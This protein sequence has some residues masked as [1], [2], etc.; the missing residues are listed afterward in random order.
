MYYVL[1]Y[2]TTLCAFMS[3][4]FYSALPNCKHIFFTIHHSFLSFLS[5]LNTQSP[6]LFLLFPFLSHHHGS[7]LHISHE[8]NIYEP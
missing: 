5:R 6:S 3:Y 4:M 2:G 1:L 7:V 8:Y